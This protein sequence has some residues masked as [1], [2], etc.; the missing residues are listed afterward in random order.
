MK[1]RL[2]ALAA[3][4]AAGTLQAQ[5]VSWNFTGGSTAPSTI[6]ENLSASISFVSEFPGNAGSCNGNVYAG[7]GFDQTNVFNAYDNNDFLEIMVNRISGSPSFTI[8]DLDLKMKFPPFGGPTQ[9][10]IFR[11]IDN[12]GWEPI[13]SDIPIVTNCGSV[14]FSFMPDEAFV[15]IGFRIVYYGGTVSGYLAVDD[16]FL[17]GLA[18]LPVKLTSFT[19][20]PQGRTT[21]LDWATA[22]EENNSGFRIQRSR[23]GQRYTTIGEVNGKGTTDLE[24][25]YQFTDEQPYSG[26]NYYRLQQIDYD[27]TSAFSPVVT[28]QLRGMGAK[29]TP[30]VE[31]QEAVTLTLEAPLQQQGQVRILDATGKVISQAVLAP[32]QDQFRINTGHLPTGVYF[33]HLEAEGQTTQ[34]RF[35]K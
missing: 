11:N 34:E 28:A 27:G 22:S 2:L 20:R 21:V 15:S 23:D 18:P 24:Q 5:I 16:V 29:L 7:V 9:Y 13:V 17:S 8:T 1:L 26:I 12:A 25:R 3:F 30:T 31:V 4:L 6:N 33:L 10:A 32:G 35:I 19:A 14:G